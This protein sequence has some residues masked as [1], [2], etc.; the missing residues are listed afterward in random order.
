MSKAIFFRRRIQTN[1][2]P[3][4]TR[5]D[6]ELGLTGSVPD[7]TRVAMLSNGAARLD[8]TVTSDPASALP[9]TVR[10]LMNALAP[11]MI[12]EF[13]PPTYPTCSI[14]T[15]LILVV[16][17]GATVYD[18]IPCTFEAIGIEIIS[19]GIG[20]IDLNVCLVGWNGQ[21]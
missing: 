1:I 20:D 21:G 17:P 7:T 8:L 15:S 13:F 5:I 19:A 11:T 16:P 3:G 14:P 4:S 9:V 2:K 6:W 12:D 18:S 10:V